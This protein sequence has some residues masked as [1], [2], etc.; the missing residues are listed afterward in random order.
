MADLCVLSLN[1]E[2]IAGKLELSFPDV[3]E[4]LRCSGAHEGA[5]SL[6]HRYP[7]GL[8]GHGLLLVVE[9]DEYGFDRSVMDFLRIMDRRCPTF[10]DE[11]VVGLLVCSSSIDFTKSQSNHLIYLL[12]RRG[13]AFPGHPVVEVIEG[14]MN[15]RTWQNH[16]ALPREEI[17]HMQLH[18]LLSRIS[19]TAETQP[20]R[21]GATNILVVHASDRSRSNTWTLWQMVR[22]KLNDQGFKP[23]IVELDFSGQYIDDCSACSFERCLAFG[24][25]NS[26][27]HQ[28]QVSRELYSALQQAS[29]V[30]WLAPNYNDALSGRLSSIINR[31]SAPYRQNPFYDKRTHSIV[32]SGNSGCN[33]VH[34]QL[35]G[36]LTVNKGFLLPPKATLSA[37][38]NDPRDV[39]SYPHIEELAERFALNLCNQI[40]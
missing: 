38:A 36:A 27:L 33:S 16:L 29:D 20:W 9:S 32:V 13:A 26:C 39:L 18:R 4:L 5:L 8:A 1:L 6:L 10:W 21:C 2:G 31:L 34:S 28:D 12:N 35:I 25:I 14:L 24:Q 11:S 15:F 19:Q 37:I 23:I 3:T 22:Q 7:S 17:L 30:V 40:D